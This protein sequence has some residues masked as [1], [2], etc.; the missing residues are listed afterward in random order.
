M[1]NNKSSNIAN[2]M[3]KEDA[4]LVGAIVMWSIETFQITESELKTKMDSEGLDEYWQPPTI[5]K[6]AAFTQAVNLAKR[7]S[8]GHLLRYISR[9]KSKSVLG[10][11]AES[12]DKKREEL[13]YNTGCK[14]TYSNGTLTKTKPHKVADIISTEYTLAS[15]TYLRH[16]AHRMLTRNIKHKMN[17]IAVRP[18]GGVYFVPAEYMSILEKHQNVI[19]N[20]GNSE[21]II[22]PL[23]GDSSTKKNLNG[24]I[25]SAIVEELKELQE[26]IDKVSSLDHRIREDGL[27]TRL[28]AFRDIRKRAD[29]YKQ[30]LDV[31]ST[32]I[33]EA[34][35]LAEA[36]LQTLLGLKKEQIESKSKSKADI[37]MASVLSKV[38]ARQVIPV[39]EDAAVKRQTI[40]VEK[41][42]QSKIIKRVQ[43]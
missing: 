36:K 20:I 18:S 3:K 1:K 15:T 11:V 39:E 37:K 42:K 28:E 34:I 21:F 2:L 9:S 24:V 33:V 35:Q 29:M 17:G 13:D 5:D 31:K 22:L 30:I 40:P 12:V 16:D 38:G 14:L 41:Q 32:A 7:S 26:N 6:D 25:S 43:K 8:E 27:K 23:Y 4:P 19:N 10:I